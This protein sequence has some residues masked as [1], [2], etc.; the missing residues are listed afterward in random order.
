MGMTHYT[1]EQMQ[2]Q[3]AVLVEQRRAI[4]AQIMA[5]RSKC[6]VGNKYTEDNKHNH[7]NSIAYQWFGKR[8]KDLTPEELREYNK[9]MQIRHRESKQN[10]N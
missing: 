1:V 9:R 8:M 4:S 10:A 6:Y 2:A 5:L 7:K 3:I